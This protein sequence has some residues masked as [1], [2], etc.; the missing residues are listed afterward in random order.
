MAAEQGVRCG[1]GDGSVETEVDTGS[2]IS[3]A[4]ID[5]R[6]GQVIQARYW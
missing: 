1:D 3:L 4:V 2:R 5:G 6:V